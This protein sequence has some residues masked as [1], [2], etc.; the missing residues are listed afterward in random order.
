MMA[1][2]SAVRAGAVKRFD[3]RIPGWAPTLVASPFAMTGLGAQRVITRCSSPALQQPGRCL[4]NHS[5][6]AP[7][8]PSRARGAAQG[9]A[10]RLPLRAVAG[11]AGRLGGG[12]GVDDGRGLT[13]AVLVVL[14]DAAE[15]GDVAAVAEHAPAPGR[16]GLEQTQAVAEVRALPCG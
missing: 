6:P 7:S 14:E 10:E 11:L 16:G 12:V 15:P 2:N 13:G 3:T 9:H 5:I 1:Q 4:S 8:R